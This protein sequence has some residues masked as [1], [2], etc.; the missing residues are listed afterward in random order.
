M[1]L[2]SLPSSQAHTPLQVRDY[3]DAFPGATG[4]PSDTTAAGRAPGG[5]MS[6]PRARSLQPSCLTPGSSHVPAP[7]ALP[8]SPLP[9][10]C[11]KPT[12]SPA[13]APAPLQPEHRRPGAVP[14]PA[15]CPHPS[16][17]PLRRARRMRPCRQRSPMQA[18]VTMLTPAM[19]FQKSTWSCSSRSVLGAQH[20]QHQHL[21]L[22]GSWQA[23]AGRT[24]RAGGGGGRGK[25]P[26]A[27]ED[28]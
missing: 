25:A 7:K 8:R 10:G 27:E 11:P 16:A 5:C 13:P 1:E 23:A 14:H 20:P 6:D 26:Q 17:A 9:P 15:R 12:A 4:C 3:R 18:A 28:S 21:G 19:D 22:A 2:D 24:A